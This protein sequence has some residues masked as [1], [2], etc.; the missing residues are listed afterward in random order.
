MWIKP[1]T[2]PRV[3]VVK[4]DRYAQKVMLCF[5]WNF[6]EIFHFEPVQNG[7]VGAKLCNKEL[8][9][10]YVA[11]VDR[12]PAALINR[13]HAL[14]LHV[15]APTAHTAALIESKIMEPPEI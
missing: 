6:E 1:A 4:Q 7:V 13:K 12:Y 10:I 5:C 3:K 14:L 11:L 2:Q 8:D 9:C 15:N